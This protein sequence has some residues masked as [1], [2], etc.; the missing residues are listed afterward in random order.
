MQAFRNLCISLLLI[1]SAC[2]SQVELS[3]LG[4]Y[5][6]IEEVRFQNG[7]SKTF[8]FS[9]TVDFFQLIDENQGIMKKLDTRV[10]GKFFANEA[11]Q[12]FTLQK[13]S[14]EAVL[15]QIEGQEPIS[16]ELK[17]LTTEELHLYD[18]KLSRLLVY[19]KFTPLNY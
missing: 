14:N 4:G 2:K 19:R 17:K 1:L 12:R 13:D 7:S 8:A 3:Q 5:W 18:Q 11:E 6:Q 9:S 15:I 10:D 16:Y